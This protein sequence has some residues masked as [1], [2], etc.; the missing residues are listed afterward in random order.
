MAPLHICEVVIR[1]AVADALEAVYGPRWPWETTFV[2]SLP[3]PSGS[4]YN[5]RRDLKSAAA[6]QPSTGKVIPELKFVFWQEMFTHRHDVRLWN[7]H[8]KRIFPSYDPAITVVSLRKAVYADLEAIRKLRN[9]IAHHE[10]IFTRNLKTDF[11]RMLKL[12]EQR[13]P[14][15]A[16]WMT[17][18]Q[19]ASRFIS[20]P[21]VFR[22]GKLWTHSH[23]E[24]AQLAY[25]LW[26][27]GGMRNN[28]AEADWARAETLL[29][30]FDQ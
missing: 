3:N 11:E 27:D 25:R 13:S 16:S 26:C 7:T 5:S 30:L 10:P 4:Y 22:G 19:Y 28:T 9:R 24:T 1:N 29:G 6:K 20:Q 2:L 8:I 15:V 14:L 17:A 21:A 23:E 12:V 18:N